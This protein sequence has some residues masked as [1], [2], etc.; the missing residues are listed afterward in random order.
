MRHFIT[1]D[2][3][4]QQIFRACLEAE[5][6]RELALLALRRTVSCNSKS[7]KVH[8]QETSQGI[9]SVSSLSCSWSM[10]SIKDDVSVQDSGLDINE[11]KGLKE[12]NQELKLENAKLHSELLSMEETIENQRATIAL[13]EEDLQESRQ[14][15]RMFEDHSSLLALHAEEVSESKELLV[16]ALE[17]R[18]KQLDDLKVENNEMMK[19]MEEKY[20]K[21]KEHNAFQIKKLEETAAV[22]EEENAKLKK[23]VHE[24][25]LHNQAKD[26]ISAV[27]CESLRETFNED[28]VESLK[29]NKILEDELIVLKKMNID[30]KSEVAESISLLEDWKKKCTLCEEKISL[31]TIQL[32][33]ANKALRIVENDLA[34]KERDREAM[35]ARN[36]EEIKKLTDDNQEKV[37]RECLKNEWLEQEIAQHRISKSELEE[38]FKE[39]EILLKSKQITF[40]AIL[41]G[42]TTSCENEAAHH[43][44]EIEEMQAK[45]E[46]GER[47]Y[48]F[49]LDK[50]S[51]FICD[52]IDL[53]EWKCEDSEDSADLLN[54]QPE[55]ARNSNAMKSQL[56]WFKEKCC[57]LEEIRNDLEANSERLQLELDSR[58]DE[59]KHLYERLTMCYEK[60]NSKDITIEQLSVKKPKRRGFRR[61]LCC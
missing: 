8:N 55:D 13:R 31:L 56:R 59:V 9:S 51:M 47:R 22:T 35:N 16:D 12:E 46:E 3:F 27:I 50:S 43:Q 25:D 38:K 49:L 52:L 60:L 36:I 19:K 44:K 34:V 33:E 29:R 37:K 48:N 32:D 26:I 18:E 39:Q 1:I 10:S 61:L 45:I 58:E 21:E 20:T 7:L 2:L 24:K 28:L 11:M 40:D 41:R 17:L 4:F 15:W 57:K 30:Q 54:D 23:H 5:K 42:I 53:K 14:K 6:Q